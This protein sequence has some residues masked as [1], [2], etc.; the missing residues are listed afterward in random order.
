MI[1]SWICSAVRG[2]DGGERVALARGVGHLASVRDNDRGMP[3]NPRWDE[4]D[5]WDEQAG[6]T[7]ALL[8]QGGTDAV[9]GGDGDRIGGERVSRHF[10][11][12]CVMVGGYHTLQ[13]VG[14]RRF[15]AGG[16]ERRR[17]GA[18]HCFGT[19]CRA[20]CASLGQRLGDAPEPPMGRAGRVGRVGHSFATATEGRRAGVRQEGLSAERGRTEFG[21][22]DCGA[23]LFT[24][25]GR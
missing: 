4:R 19:G 10:L 11:M 14:G 8:P 1:P 24:A 6:G 12:E 9:G 5:V 2:A 3:P 17:L 21:E 25:G 23:G 7:A 18:R 16:L 15:R 22:Q 13:N 20:L